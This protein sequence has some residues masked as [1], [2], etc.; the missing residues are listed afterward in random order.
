MLVCHFVSILKAADVAKMAAGSDFRSN[1]N[2][3]RPFSYFLSLWQVMR[4]KMIRLRQRKRSDGK[5]MDRMM[6]AEER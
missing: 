3:M 6:E 2:G 1:G 4:K 5:E